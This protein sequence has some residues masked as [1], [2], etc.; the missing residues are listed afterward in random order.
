MDEI[1][2]LGWCPE[3]SW[4]AFVQLGMRCVRLKAKDRP[5]LVSEVLPVLKSL[6]TKEAAVSSVV[7]GAHS[8]A[9]AC[10]TVL[11]DALPQLFKCPLTSMAMQDPVFAADG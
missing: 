9:G 3:S 10:A 1:L 6:A 2:R 8:V 11:P 7:E 5:G 4:R